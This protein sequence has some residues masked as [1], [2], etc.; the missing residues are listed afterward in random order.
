MNK[1]LFGFCIGS[2]LCSCSNKEEVKNKPLAPYIISKTDRDLK[3]SKIPSP[4]IPMFYGS[5]NFILD[6][7]NTV[8]YF[9]RP[10][11][12]FICVTGMLEDTIPGFGELVPDQLIKI[13]V[14]NISEFVKQNLQAGFRNF[15][16]IA[17]QKDTL[18][19]ELFFELVKAVKNSTYKDDRDFYVI[20]R[21]WQEEDTVL[22]Y[23]KSN[24]YYSSDEIKWDKTKIKFIE[25]I[26]EI[27]PPSK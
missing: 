1:I 26:D 23:K 21:T 5:N 9:Q 25:K 12:G 2:V 7:N 19:S 27:S 3:K 14:K 15:T 22:Q 8:Y 10:E 18:N 24:K 17:S 4:P 11:I 6:K 20:R 16:T 13:P